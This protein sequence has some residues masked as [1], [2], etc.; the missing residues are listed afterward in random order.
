MDQQ[1]LQIKS[2]SIFSIQVIEIPRKYLISFPHVVQCKCQIFTL[3][4]DWKT[5]SDR[6]MKNVFWGGGNEGKQ[7]QTVSE[8]R[9]KRKVE[10]KQFSGERWTE[11]DFQVHTMRQIKL[12][13]AF[14]FKCHS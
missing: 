2:P 14:V 6:E 9:N 8:R 10:K 7:R 4:R 5:I 12:H 11:L 13:T 3:F 1:F